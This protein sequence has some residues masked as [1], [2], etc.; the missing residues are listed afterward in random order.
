MFPEFRTP[1]LREQHKQLR[2]DWALLVLDQ[3]KYDRE[4]RVD[5][6]ASSERSHSCAVETGSGETDRDELNP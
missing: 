4:R 2:R 3:P 5:T 1:D 6:S